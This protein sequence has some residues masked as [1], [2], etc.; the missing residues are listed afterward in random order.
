MREKP[1]ILLH[2]CCGPCSTAVVERLETDFNITLFFYNPNITNQE[3]YRSRITSQAQYLRCYNQNRSGSEEI[4]LL[5]G[6]YDTAR[7][8]EEILGLEQEPEGGSRCAKCISLR[9]EET[10]EEAKKRGFSVFGTTL[11]VS[12]HKDHALI[13]RIGNQLA[14]ERGLEFL[15]DDF[16]KRGGYQRSIELSKQY[17]LYRQN[18]CGCEYSKRKDN[19]SI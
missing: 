17:G 9:L 10:A 3:E 8:H 11:S 1:S 4:L 12:S 5:E 2:S 6:Q 7:F 19:N 15:T 13:T 14:T 16:K 18:Y